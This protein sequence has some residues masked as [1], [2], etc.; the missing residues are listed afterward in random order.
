MIEAVGHEYLDD[1]FQQC[2]RLLKPQGSMLLQAIVMPDRG[3]QNYLRSVDFIRRYIF[4]GG[5]LP[6]VTSILDSVIA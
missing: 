6:S 4:P 3:Y 5:C 2:G 1:Y